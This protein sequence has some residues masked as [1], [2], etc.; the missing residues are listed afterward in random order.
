MLLFISGDII[1]A[2]TYVIEITVHTVRGSLQKCGGD[3]FRFVIERRVEFQ[4]LLEPFDFFIGPR[5]TDHVTS[6]ILGDLS[7]VTA[8]GSGRRGDDDGFPGFRVA[9]V[10]KSEQ[11]G[12]SEI[13]EKKKMNVYTDTCHTYLLY[14]KVPTAVA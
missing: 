13:E 1:R 7:H 11:S 14:P 4:N 12:V 9:Y 6:Q 2:I 5:E 3:V 8:H 10:Q